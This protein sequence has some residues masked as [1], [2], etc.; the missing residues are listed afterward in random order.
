MQPITHKISV[1]LAKNG[2]PVV[3]DATQGDALSRKVEA[4]LYNNGTLWTIPD[5]VTGAV[6]TYAKADGKGGSYDKLPDNSAAISVGANS[7]SVILAPQV[8]TCPGLVRAAIKLTGANSLALFTF[9]FLISVARSPADGVKSDD[10]SNVA[11]LEELAADVAALDA[12]VSR[13]V[14]TVNGKQR[15]T[16]GNVDVGADDIDVEIRASQYQGDLS[17]ALEDLGT[18][19]RVFDIAVTRNADGTMSANKTYA[20]IKAAYQDGRELRVLL[21]DKKDQS[22]AV[23]SLSQYAG[24]ATAAFVFSAAAEIKQ[25]EWEIA[26]LSINSADAWSHEQ[27]FFPGMPS[28]ANAGKFLQST[29]TGWA[30]AD[31]SSAAKDGTADWA[32]WAATQS[33]P[34]DWIGSWAAAAG[35]TSDTYR[36]DNG[37]YRVYDGEFWHTVQISECAAG[38]QIIEYYTDDTDAFCFSVFIASTPG[39][40]LKSVTSCDGSRVKIFGFDISVPYPSNKQVGYVLT[41][42]AAGT[43]AWQPLPE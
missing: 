16:A 25:D 13:C 38:R 14:K 32:A 36:V 26:D 40:E 7:V 1:D 3:V 27:Y 17:G 10:Y 8:L 37:T 30:F 6:M 31:A 2:A 4:T 39:G 23:L 42:T 43:Y 12:E 21:T 29:G 35:A 11:T 9:P 34:A 33:R 18:R 19:V 15:D 20:Q 41:A 24:T 28:S 5:D 22:S